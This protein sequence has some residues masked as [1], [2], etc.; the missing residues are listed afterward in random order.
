MG[1]TNRNRTAPS[2][3]R[4]TIRT[5]RRALAILRAFRSTDRE[6]PLGEIALRAQLDKGTTHRLL[7]TL[8]VERLVEQQ[9]AGM[10]YSLGIGV[11]ELAAGLTREGDLRQRTQ[12]VLAA[13]AEATG[14]TAFL[15]IVHD[16]QALCIGR[17]D[18]G[19]A[20]QIRSWSVGGRL[21]LNGG[22]GPRVLMANMPAADQARL[23]AGKL[24]AVTARTPTDPGELRERLEQIRERGWD[25]SVNEIIEGVASVAVPVRG[26][27][28]AVIAT[29]SISGLTPHMMEDGQAR[30]L[31]ELQARVRK[32]E[33]G[34]TSE[35]G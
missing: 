20:I 28:G 11:L 35:K 18:G 32:L 1:E 15:G 19:L 31:P 3:D 9:E 17:V 34:L 12:P 2:E 22:A 27:D 29:I 33:A 7:R 23:L 8:I 5:V 26:R 13:L 16:D 10:T 30:H 24:E 4:A 21:P 14:T 25:I 6:L